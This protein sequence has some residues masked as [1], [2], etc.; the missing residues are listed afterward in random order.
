[1]RPQAL[2]NLWHELTHTVRSFVP[3]LE[4]LPTAYD[5][6]TTNFI[7][8]RLAM[9][10]AARGVK[11]RY[12]KIDP[13]TIAS[14]RLGWRRNLV[15]KPEIVERIFEKYTADGKLEEEYKKKLLED[16]ARGLVLKRKVREAVMKSLKPELASSKLRDV[17][18]TAEAREYL[19]KNYSKLL[20]QVKRMPSKDLEEAMEEMRKELP[21]IE[22]YFWNMKRG[23]ERFGLKVIKR[24]PSILVRLKHL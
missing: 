21:R 1:M 13:A 8:D 4:K 18:F 5:E 9:L 2:L 7:A 12:L 20:R 24:R 23:K 15:Y 19:R 22:K 3:Q 14:A 10:F 6:A 17:H 16:F 11:G